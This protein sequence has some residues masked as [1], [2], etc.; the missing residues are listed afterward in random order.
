M[1][2]DR[3]DLQTQAGKLFLQSE[4]FLSLGTAK[5]IENRKELG[6]EMSSRKSG[7]FFICTIQK[8]CEET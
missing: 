4:D 7:C 3:E 5:V 1:I 6:E 8:F 2:V